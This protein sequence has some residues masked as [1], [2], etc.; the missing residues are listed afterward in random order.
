[1]K[2]VCVIDS[3]GSGG[4]QRQLVNLAIGLKER[5]HQVAFITYHSGAHF[6]DTL[7]SQGIPLNRLMVQSRVDKVR[8]IR[9]MLRSLKPDAV[10]AFLDGPWLYSFLAG[11]PTRDW[12]LIVGER[13]ANPELF[14]G[15]NLALRYTY[16]FADRVVTN[17]ISNRR[18]LLSRLPFL[19]SKV[20]TIYNAVR[21]PGWGSVVG[22]W[23]VPSCRS[24]KCRIVI[25]AR[26]DK[27]KNIS[28]VAKAALI[29]N[30]SAAL[31]QVEIHWFGEQME[32]N[33]RY[34]EGQQYI[35]DSGE[36]SPVFIHAPCQNIL[37]EFKTASAVGLF[38]FYEGLPNSICEGMTCGKPIVMSDVCDARIL[39]EEGRNGF[40]CDP[41]D[42]KSIATALVRLASIDPMLEYQMGCESLRRARVLFSSER[43]V[44]RFERL[45][46]R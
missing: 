46:M 17:S 23:T 35:T 2:I 41:A 24:D 36:A 31:R 20:C 9:A 43:M 4:A 40:L 28:N 34:Q 14:R 39:V 6:V 13:S 21:E 18:M 33:R 12:R 26:I 32:V 5:G 38:S 8:K 45:L 19:S 44:R 22:G 7:L 11:L 30:Q 3:L 37:E 42:Y 25:A 29:A 27:N 10:I 1:M 16:I 15:I